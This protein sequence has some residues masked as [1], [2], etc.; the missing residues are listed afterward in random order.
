MPIYKKICLLVKHLI[1][2]PNLLTNSN[3][4]FKI[5]YPHKP[6]ALKLKTIQSN[7]LTKI[8]PIHI[9]LSYLFFDFIVLLLTL[10]A[11]SYSATFNWRTLWTFIRPGRVLLFKNENRAVTQPQFRVPLNVLADPLKPECRIGM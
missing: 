4:I 1:D 9:F 5:M 6:Q 11:H 7:P 3:R 8:I 10:I 2:S